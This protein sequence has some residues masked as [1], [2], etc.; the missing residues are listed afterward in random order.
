[1]KLTYSLPWL[2]ERSEKGD[3]LTY[4]YFW[5]HSA[6]AGTPGKACLSQWYPSPFI[7]NNVTYPTAEHWMMSEK[8]RLFGDMD[9]ARKIA[10]C[11]DPKDAKALGREVRLYNDEIWNARRYEIVVCGNIHKFN[12]NRDLGEYLLSTA[13]SILT[14]ASPVDAVWGIGL[15]ADSP[16]IENLY[17]WRGQNL[18]GFA[19]M[20]V[21]DFL[22]NYG[23]FDSTA[24]NFPAPWEQYPGK[25][26]HDMFWRRGVGEDCIADFATAYDALTEN[27]QALYKVLHPEPNGW[28]FYSE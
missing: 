18:L 23:F 24:H 14:E 22:K 3:A 11:E 21:R 12:Q 4:L 10:A 6:S 25:D 27:E 2:I 28:M 13:D 16:D 5:G 8:A 15:A 17:L 20:E 1:M 19:L 9:T 7:V 26:E